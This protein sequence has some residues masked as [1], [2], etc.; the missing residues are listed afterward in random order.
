[1]WKEVVLA[2]FFSLER[3]VA[4]IVADFDA[5]SMKQTAL[6][7]A[8]FETEHVRLS[9]KAAT[10]PSKEQIGMH[11]M[12]ARTCRHMVQF[13]CPKAAVITKFDNLGIIQPAC[14]WPPNEDSS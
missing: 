10:K 9:A 11:P 4:C 5:V 3:K 14:I 7:P 8:S 6:L 13:S 1:M 12:Q 2:L